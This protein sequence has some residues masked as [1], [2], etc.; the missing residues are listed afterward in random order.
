MP[1]Y[2]FIHPVLAV[3]T[4]GLG[5]VTAQTSLSK[6][7]DWDFPLRRQRGRTIIFFLLVIA[8]FI[9][10]LFVNAG[11]RVIHKGV[12]ITGHLLLSIIVLAVGF[13]ATLVTFARSRPGETP[14]LM[15][16]HSMLLI[17]ALA[18]M[19]TMGFLGALNLFIR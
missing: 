11:L 12:N 15:R 9:I 18:L 1:W 8:N 5:L 6:I 13:L 7:S 3:V 2:G 10:G 4:I 17:A 14:P 19:L 16:W